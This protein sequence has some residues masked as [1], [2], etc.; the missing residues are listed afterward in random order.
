[1]L[2]VPLTCRWGSF[3]LDFTWCWCATGMKLKY[4]LRCDVWH[5]GVKPS[6]A[7]LLWL[8]VKSP[9]LPSTN[10][11]SISP[12]EPFWWA[13]VT[14][15]PQRDRSLRGYVIWE[16][17]VT[18]LP[19]I[20][21]QMQIQGMVIVRYSISALLLMYEIYNFD[22]HSKCS[23]TKSEKFIFHQFLNRFFHQLSALLFV[24]VD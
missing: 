9:A 1:M 12:L 2:L 6:S 7:Y 20:G 10:D 8:S 3:S 15:I 23:N 11:H 21:L 13:T 17:H 5:G 16:C 14:Q 22:S 24:V 18:T 4:L 19:W